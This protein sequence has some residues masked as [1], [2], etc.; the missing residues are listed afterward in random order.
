MVQARAG[1]LRIDIHESK[2]NSLCVEYDDLFKIDDSR[3]QNKSM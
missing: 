3:I 1:H 2:R